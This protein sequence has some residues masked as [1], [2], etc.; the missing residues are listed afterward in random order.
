MVTYRQASEADY[1]RINDF[2]NR[3]YAAQRTLAQFR[4][5]FHDAPAGPSIYIIAEDGD[6]VVGSQCVIPITLIDA[7]G[8]HI[9]SGKSED[10]LLDPAYRGQGIFNKL[11]ELLFQRCSE[12]G[13][14]V[15]W[16]FTSAAKPFEKLGFEIPYAHLQNLAVHRILPAY[17]YLIT[18]N[19]QNTALSKFKILG[20][21][22]LAKFRFAFAGGDARALAPYTLRTEPT[23]S[24]NEVLLMGQL[25]RQPG[26]FCILQ[27]QA[28]QDWR[29][30]QNPNYHAVRTY[31]YYDAQGQLMASIV[32]NTKPN[33]V[34]YLIQSLFHADL[35]AALVAAMLRGA[36][37]ALFATGITLVR[38][39]VFA[40]NAYQT[41]EVAA[42]EQAGYHTLARGIGLVWKPMDGY[43]LA[44]QGF[45]L[46]RIATQG[47]V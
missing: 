3:I 24:G 19:P 40:H 43:Q 39:W 26:G 17:R 14:Q 13:I 1:P 46:S 9:R 23:P 35:S 5:E 30:Y 8:R 33:Q 47:T 45:L 41:A 44:P 21:S 4:W 18:L 6:K 12:A 20:L 32:F 11:Y 34:A 16:G 2:Y 10:T 28:F 37:Q 31:G 36:T 38:N 25:Q 15:I 7:E 27:D 29:V 22:V 42:F